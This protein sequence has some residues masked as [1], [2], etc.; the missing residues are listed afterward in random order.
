MSSNPNRYQTSKPN[1]T[2][3][4]TKTNKLRNQTEQ[5]PK[6]KSNYDTEAI[7]AI[8]IVRLAPIDRD[9][10]YEPYRAILRGPLSIWDYGGLIRTPEIAC[11]AFLAWG[12]IP[13][14]CTCRCGR[15]MRPIAR[16]NQLGFRWMC[17]DGCG[18]KSALEGTFF[19]RSLLCPLSVARLLYHFLVKDKLVYA[20]TSTGLAKTTVVDWYNFFREVLDVIQDQRLP[21]YW[22]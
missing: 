4:E 6:A 22:R 2:N 10:V 5:T 21:T 20:S 1:Q 11:K 12:I 15:Q 8:G 14:R 13:D 18:V 3:F 19:E 16:D 9:P 7:P 17:S